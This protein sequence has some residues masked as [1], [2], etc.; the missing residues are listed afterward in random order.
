[1]ST[2]G[3]SSSGVSGVGSGNLLQITGLASNL[4]TTSI[5]NALMALDRAPLTNLTNQQKAL[6]A[7]NTQLTNIQTSLQTLALNAQALNSPGLFANTQTATSS[8]STRVAATAT[9]GA[10][11]GGYQVA[12]TQL[13][14]SSQK[15]FTFASPATDQTFTIDNGAAIT[16][17][18]GSTTTDL[19]NAI[20]SDSTQSVYASAID[21]THIM[22]SSRTTGAPV[23]PN[24]FIVVGGSPSALTQ[25][26]QSAG[27]DASYS[28]DNGPAQT[29]H[30][31]TITGAIAGVTLNLMGVTTTSGP[32]TVSVSP[33]APS[34][35]GIEAAVKSFVDSYNAV[36]DQISTQ[37]SQ[38]PTSSDPT[39]GTLYGD[40]ELTDLLSN[41][42]EAVYTPNTALTGIQSLADVGITTGA[43]AGDAPYSQDSVNGKLTIDTTKLEA[44]LASNPNGVKAMLQGWS[45]S[46]ATVVNGVAAPGGTIDLRIQGDNSELS[47]LSNQI[48]DLNAMLTDRQTA[49]QSQFAD[50]ETALQQSQSQSNWLM[51]QIAGLPTG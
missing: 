46:F 19:A 29:S 31:N 37:T 28:I 7:R 17:K 20:N 3:L 11:I 40:N 32:V 33:P 25:T 38:V 50:L 49:L 12:V 16:I 43:A 10:A 5:I 23:D 9:S 35:S 14:N 15:T 41:M 42:R 8:D 47:D 24:N 1:M 4:D 6:Q 22:F 27:H 30:T 39:Q 2:S 36:L 51:S 44:A 26:A 21:D 34:T 18:A 13:A 48:S 45:D